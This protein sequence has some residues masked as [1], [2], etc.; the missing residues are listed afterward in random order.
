M[1][2]ISV[3]IPTFNQAR[4]LGEAIDSALAQLRKP[5]EVIVVDD[6]STDETPAVLE[7]Y[8]APVRVIRQQ[9]GGVAAARNAGVAAARGEYVAFLDSDDVWH[10]RKLFR[11]MLRFD[12]DPALGLVHCGAEWFDDATGRSLGID[13]DGGEGWIA[14]ELL[15]LE[16]TVIAAGGSS[17]MLP[18]RVLNEAGG[19]DARLRVAEDWEL[20]FRV[21]RRYRVAYVPEVLVRYR[22]H[23]AGIHRNTRAYHCA[24]MLALH[25]IFSARDADDLQHLKQRAYGAVHRTLAACYLSER[26]MRSFAQHALRSVLYDERNVGYFAAEVRAKL[27][28]TPPSPSNTASPYPSN[29]RS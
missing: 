26:E 21:A 24:M 12:V 28:L 7:R 3:V 14:A 1:R 17:P 29:R 2:S 15:R 6:G 8:G 20:S 13:L 19:Y 27:G 22:V 5:L 18:R 16:R 11:Q 4:Y 9:N 25:K 23:G 10:P